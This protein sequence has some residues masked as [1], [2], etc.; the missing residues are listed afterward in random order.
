MSAPGVN[1]NKRKRP[2][3]KPKA[4]AVTAAA[5]EAATPQ[6]GSFQS[7]PQATRPAT[8]VA[9]ESSRGFTNVKFDQFL[10]SGQISQATMNGIA[11]LRP[12]HE[13]W[14]VATNSAS[15]TRR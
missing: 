3:R 15:S 11:S 6:L 1:P 4:A 8:P 10:A 2:F 12:V 13:F 7:T 5:P 14:S 9:G